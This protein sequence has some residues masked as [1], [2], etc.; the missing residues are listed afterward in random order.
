[1]KL[2]CSIS[3]LFIELSLF[4]SFL[5][6]HFCWSFFHVCFLHPFFKLCFLGTFQ[7]HLNFQKLCHE[8]FHHILFCFWCWQPFWSHHC[9]ISYCAGTC[10]SLPSV[11]LT[12][13]PRSVCLSVFPVFALCKHSDVKFQ[14]NFSLWR[15]GFGFFL[16]MFFTLTSTFIFHPIKINLDLFSSFHW[17][18]KEAHLTNSQ[19]LTVCAVMSVLSY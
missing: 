16:L 6:A 17:S 14:P 8:D 18:S 15:T 10:M 19:L 11:F 13:L 9:R 4:V 7:I 3:L 5:F 1:M 12:N 2:T